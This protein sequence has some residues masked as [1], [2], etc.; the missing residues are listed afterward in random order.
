MYVCI[1]SAV[2]EKDIHR[3]VAEGCRSADDLRHHLGVA[4]GCGRCLDSAMETLQ[5]AMLPFAARFDVASRLNV[6][7]HLN[8]A[9]H[10]NVVDYSLAY[11]A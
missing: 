11:P 3:A 2:T 7:A 1:C 4:A 6:A 9:S 10:L 8:V 5:Q